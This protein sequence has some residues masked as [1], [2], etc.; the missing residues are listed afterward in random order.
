MAIDLEGI[1]SFPHY[2]SFAA[3]TTATEIKV[4][5]TADFVQVQNTDAAILIHIGQNGQTDAGTWVSGKQF[6][7]PAANQAKE[8]RL[9]EGS[10]GAGSI[11]IASAS[12]T[13]TVNL[14]FT[15]AGR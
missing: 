12:G 5:E 1:N 8:I 15:K 11:F 7:I 9:N 4:P 10:S 13:P 3:A 14:E 2:H 6:T